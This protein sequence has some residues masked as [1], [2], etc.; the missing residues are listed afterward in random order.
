MGRQ[1]IIYTVTNVTEQVLL[2][3]VS[4]ANIAQNYRYQKDVKY[5]IFAFLVVESYRSYVPEIAFKGG[6]LAN[7]SKLHIP[8]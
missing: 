1:K 8:I 2:N 4:T 7:I 6:T 3:S 5:G